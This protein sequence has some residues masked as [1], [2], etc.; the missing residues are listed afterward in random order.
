MPVHRPTLYRSTARHASLVAALAALVGLG[1][2]EDAPRIQPTKQ[3][4]EVVRAN[5]LAAAGHRDEAIALLLLRV[6]DAPEDSIAK[7]KPQGCPM[8]RKIFLI[9]FPVLAVTLVLGDE[10]APQPARAQHRT[11]MSMSA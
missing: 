10:P 2:A 3:S 9:L 6:H 11:G 7:T 1:V 5:A 8:G 4:D